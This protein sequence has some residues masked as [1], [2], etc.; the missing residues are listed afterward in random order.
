MFWVYVLRSRS[1]PRL[2]VGQTADLRR[3]L[4]QHADKIDFPNAFTARQPGPWLLV[5]QERHH[6]RTEALKRERWL[7]SGEGRA[8]LAVKLQSPGPSVRMR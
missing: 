5:H 8:W 6:T 3:R 1:N 7:N 4:Q 2:Y